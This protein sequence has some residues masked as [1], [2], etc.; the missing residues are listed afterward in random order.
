MY[1]SQT[2]N[3]KEKKEEDDDDEVKNEFFIPRGYISEDEEEKDEDEV[4]DMKK[5]LLF[6][7]KEEVEKVEEVEEIKEVEEAK[8]IKTWENDIQGLY[9]TNELAPVSIKTLVK[10]AKERETDN[11]DKFMVYKVN[12]DNANV[13]SVFSESHP[14]DR[15]VTDG[16]EAVQ[17]VENQSSSSNQEHGLP[18][19]S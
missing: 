19:S 1:A 15:K 9:R 10:E 5:M 14:V 12:Q 18:G 2:Y 8:E 11:F 3:K 6:E 13:I 17:D 7:T 4:F 16:S